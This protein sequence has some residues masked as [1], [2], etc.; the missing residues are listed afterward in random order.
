MRTGSF[1]GDDSICL[2]PACHDERLGNQEGRRPESP[3]EC[4]RTAG[5]PPFPKDGRSGRIR[6]VEPEEVVTLLPAQFRI[7]GFVRESRRSGKDRAS[8]AVFSHAEPRLRGNITVGK[9]LFN[10][11][12]EIPGGSL[13]DKMKEGDLVLVQYPDGIRRVRAWLRPT[14]VIHLIK[15]DV[16][17]TA[18]L[19][20]PIEGRGIYHTPIA[21]MAD[22]TPWGCSTNP[23]VSVTNTNRMNA[24]WARLLHDLPKKPEGAPL[25]GNQVSGAGPVHVE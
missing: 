18:D 5:K 21:P 4:F 7:S 9:M 16:T 23:S 12:H 8:L 1:S 2:D 14:F 19:G 6:Q 11:Q 3:C 20:D 15:R 13:E 25:T 22:V 24:E 17:E 10:T